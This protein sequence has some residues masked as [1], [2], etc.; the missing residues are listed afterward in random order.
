MLN[1]RLRRCAHVPVLAVRGKHAMKACQVDSWLGHQGGEPGHE[2]QGLEDHVRGAIAIRR[3]RRSCAP[4]ALP[5]VALTVPGGRLAV[6]VG[7][8]DHGR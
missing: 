8:A 4:R 5:A 7:D 6:T 1:T 2:V 3:L